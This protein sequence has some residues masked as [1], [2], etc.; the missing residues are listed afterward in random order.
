MCGFIVTNIAR[1]DLDAANRYVG[2]R[3]PDGTNV[4]THDGVTFLHDLL[5]ITG[6]ITAQPFHD[7]EYVS[8]FNGEIYNFQ[9]FGDLESDGQCLIPAFRRFDKIGRAHV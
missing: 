9:D 5:S 2:K 6:K 4:E 1:P 8:L 3:G 7:D